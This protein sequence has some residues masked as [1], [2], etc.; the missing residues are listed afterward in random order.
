[1]FSL[2][3]F[4]L[5]SLM[6]VLFL[7]LVESDLT[8]YQQLNEVNMISDIT[9]IEIESEGDINGFFTIHYNDGSVRTG[10]SCDQGSIEMDDEED[11]DDDLH[12]LCMD[13]W[14]AMDIDPEDMNYRYRATWTKDNGLG[15]TTS[16]EVD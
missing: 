6:S 3:W 11:L 8:Y 5:S 1:M 2:S 15:A 13:Q 14:F 7:S 10:W 9:K 12:N 4:S 16:E